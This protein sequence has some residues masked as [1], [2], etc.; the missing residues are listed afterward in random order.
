MKSHGCLNRLEGKGT[1]L[2]LTMVKFGKR[3]VMKFIKGVKDI[4][5]ALPVC[6]PKV[7]AHPRGLLL[8]GLAIVSG[9][10]NSQGDD[11]T[12]SRPSSRTTITGQCA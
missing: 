4:H 1:S 6:K 10:S 12:R 3:A 9:F 5:G 7:T 11:E 8:A 2:S